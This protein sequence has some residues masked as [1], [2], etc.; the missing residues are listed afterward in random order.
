MSVHTRRTSRIF[1][2][3]IETPYGRVV[4]GYRIE[5]DGS[6]GR[7]FV[8]HSDPLALHPTSSRFWFAMSAEL[9]DL[10]PSLWWESLGPA[11][12]AA[13]EEDDG[14]LELASEYRRK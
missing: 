2:I 8:F 3:T 14:P 4:L 5:A 13:E 11:G 7:P 12:R 10:G 1:P 6:L 9:Q